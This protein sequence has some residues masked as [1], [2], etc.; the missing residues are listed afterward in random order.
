MIVD[1]FA[2]AGGVS[3]GLR[4]LGRTDVVGLDNDRVAVAI[5]RAAGH[6]RILADVYGYDPRK[7]ELLYGPIEGLHGSPPCGG[8]SGGG[9]GLG[10]D[11]LGRVVDLID[12]LAE[13]GDDRA[14]YLMHWQDLRS[15][16]MAEPM[17]Y[18]LAL[19]PEWF[20]LEQV[21][22]AVSVWEEYAAHLSGWGWFVD[23]GV[24]NARW[25]GV[26]QDRER[27]ILL[28]HRWQ[29]VT[30]PAGSLVDDVPASTV[31]GA[32]TLGFPRR[33]D[34]PS[35]KTGS[36]VVTIGGVDY[37]A[38]DLRPT[39]R[40]S[41]TVT[42]KARS[43]THVSPDGDRRPLAVDEIGRLQGFPA[44]YPWLVAERSAAALRAANAVPPPMYAG[45]V[46]DV[47]TRPT[48]TS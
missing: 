20:T 18:L 45:L 3:Q 1:L 42:E 5:A 6:E 48:A 24:V 34:R 14:E 44:G 35:N 38:R 22:E 9:L 28:A 19:E 32:G 10:R 46:R 16:L 8:L 31:V 25:F 29:S 47:L 36:N 2:G 40:P 13:G 11:D 41:F 26:P 37:R 12:C 4:M 43:W 15:P 21:P 30:V 7:L 17:R 27:A 33:A 23:V 39:S